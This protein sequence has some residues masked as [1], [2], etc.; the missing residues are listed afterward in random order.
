MCLKI[1]LLL[2]IAVNY[3]SCDDFPSLLTQNASIAVIIDR[4]YLDNQYEDIHNE[5]KVIVERVLRE[6]LKN[7][8]LI[9]NYYSWTKINLRKDFSAVLSITS[10]E[11]TWEIYR[12]SRGE[13]LL[14]MAI[15][16]ADCPRLPY[17]E[18]LMVSLGIFLTTFSNFENF[19]EF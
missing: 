11:N 5:I 9:V 6:D 18:A 19:F 12:D 4:E 2:L 1:L 8:G 3:A 17:E 14:L 15:T 7:G 13:N 10:C 16:D